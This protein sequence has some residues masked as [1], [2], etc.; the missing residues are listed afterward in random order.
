MTLAMP[1]V[2]WWKRANTTLSIK[3]ASKRVQET[4]IW[5]TFLQS[6]G[7]I[8]EQVLK[9]VSMHV[10]DKK[11]TLTIQHDLLT[12]GCA[13]TTALAPVMS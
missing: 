3:G 1:G 4:Y 7:K 2:S 9:A 13:W 11:A 10:K 6:L 5:S 8:M 12:T